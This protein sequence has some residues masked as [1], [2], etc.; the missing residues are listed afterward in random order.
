MS[1]TLFQI[2]KITIL[3]TFIQKP[4]NFSQ[5]I[6]LIISTFTLLKNFPIPPTIF[7]RIPFP[8]KHS[9]MLIPISGD[10]SRGNPFLLQNVRNIQSFL[11][12]TYLLL[13]SAHIFF[14]VLILCT[15]DQILAFFFM[16]IFIFIFF[17]VFFFR[18]I[19]GFIF[20]F[21]LGFIFRLILLI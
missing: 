21:I 7:F 2:P 9:F 6:S 16:I 20:I 4:I 15:L 8:T 10:V 17:F 18:F 19:L 11:S 5:I 13:K 1:I 14:T 12:L 3:L